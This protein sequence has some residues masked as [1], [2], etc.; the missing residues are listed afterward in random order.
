L[1]DE[2]KLSKAKRY[3]KKGCPGVE[4]TVGTIN[5]DMSVYSDI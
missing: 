5:I 2:D 4:E 1:K 3:R